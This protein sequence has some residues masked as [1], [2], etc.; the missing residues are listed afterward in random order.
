MTVCVFIHSV[1]T[2]VFNFNNM[3]CIEYRYVHT[4]VSIFIIP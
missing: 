2:V 1:L 3:I 4:V